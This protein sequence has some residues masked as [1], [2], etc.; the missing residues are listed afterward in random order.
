MML[1]INKIQQCI[2]DNIA[3]HPKDITSFVAEKLGVSRQAAYIHLRTLVIS[4]KV[5]KTGLTKGVKY[6]LIT[7]SN[8][9]ELPVINSMSESDIW[10]SRIAPMLPVLTENVK[11][12]CEYGFTEMLNNVIDHSNASTVRIYLEYNVFLISFWII[13]DGVG[14]FN[15]IQQDFKLA[16]PQ[17][18][19]LELAKGK[20]TSDPEKHSGEGIFFTSRM[21]DRFTIISGTLRFVGHNNDDWLIESPDKNITGT[22]VYMEIARSAVRTTMDIF[23]L[24]TSES[25]EY[26]FEKTKIPIRLM[27]HE[28]ASLVSRSQAKRLLSRVEKFTEVILDFEGVSNIGQAFADE[29]FRIYRKSHP[30]VHLS[31]V[32]TGP[33]IV[34]MIRHVTTERD[35]EQESLSG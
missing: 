10:T 27:Q 28:G 18:S 17:Q 13:D 24:H 23:N 29:I 14:I 26:G 31:W 34:K 8:E 25:E 7:L 35:G 30:D 5:K 16:T 21:F 4:G 33:D 6:E 1:K 9:I 12:I 19:I 3:D 2:I 15:K 22:G 11:H 32:N 20:V